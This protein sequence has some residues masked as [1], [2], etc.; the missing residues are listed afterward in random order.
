MFFFHLL[1]SLDELLYELMT[2]LVFYP[3]TLWRS[4]RHPLRMMEYARSE[5]HKEGPDQFRETLRPPMFLFVTLIIAHILELEVV[6]DSNVISN[7][8]GLADLINDDTTLIV[9]RIAAFAL[10][11]VTMA[12][13]ETSLVKQP[14]NRSTL[15]QPFYAQCFLAAPFALALSLASIAIRI[16]NST[17]ETCGIALVFIATVA[18]V[19]TEAR[20]LERST[21]QP[22]ARSMANSLGGFVVCMLIL[23]ALAWVLGG[24]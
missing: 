4:V 16:S 22:W 12:T 6:G 13:I 20:W 11:P 3:V 15:Q 10:L 9:W 23:A 8:V 21:R 2:W 7:H 1:K 17:L 18:Y 24:T 19:L 14:V 5:L